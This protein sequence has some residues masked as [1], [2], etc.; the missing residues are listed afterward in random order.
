MSTVSISAGAFGGS[1]Y[2]GRGS[3][4]VRS[5][6]RMTARGRAVLLILIAT[7]LVVLAL[8]L[9]TSAGGA[10]ATGSSTPLR[11][12]TVLA[13]QS[14]WQIAGKVAPT[15]DPRDVIADIMSVNALQSTDVQPGEKLEIPAQYASGN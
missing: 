3:G 11:T 14:L 10:T 4:P 6:L 12:V 2:A 15:A 5:H 13:G 1:A 7:P 9:G 8:V